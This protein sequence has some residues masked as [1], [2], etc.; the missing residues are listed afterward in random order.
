MSI[1]NISSLT[2]VYPGGEY[3][4][5]D[6]IDLSI[7]EG[8]F[9][10]LLGPSGCG[11][12]TT[13]RM[14]AGLE[15]PSA[16]RIEID[17]RVVDDVDAGQRIPAEQRELSLVF[18]S[19]AL[20]PH[21]KVKDNVAFGPK[22]KKVDKETTKAVVADAMSK[23]A[24]SDYAE[25][26]PSEL[27][28]GQQQRVAI[29]RT[30]AAQNKI[31]LLD[32]PLSN[33]DA[34]LRLEMRSEFQRIHRD[35]GATMIFVTHD[36]WE[37]MTLATRIVV[38]D[39]GTIQQEGTPMEIYGKPANRFVAEFMGSPPINIIEMS[40]HD[41]AQKTL[42]DWLRGR[43][44]QAESAGMRPEDMNF[45]FSRDEIPNDALGLELHCSGILPTGGSY[46]IEVTDGDNIWF[47]TTS[48]L[49]GV[50]EGDDVVMWAYPKDVHLF[51]SAGMRVEHAD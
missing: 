32:E 30:L 50:R 5:V 22:I 20:W 49:P 17:G 41:W 24:I 43:G 26:Y 31:M 15:A 37:A 27:S 8:E 16:G 46:I 1:I 12:S 44:V 39:K 34:R 6:N 19:Y 40:I 14:I 25:R 29:A 35:T 45:A 11:K 23:L 47:G 36:Q 2:K 21:M 48:R 42:A 38:M 28:G 3:P 33:L 7:N 10:C 9:L 18:Q 51:D 13:L 4:A